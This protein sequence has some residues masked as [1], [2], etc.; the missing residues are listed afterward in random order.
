MLPEKM[1]RSAN[2]FALL[3][4]LYTLEATMSDDSSDA[5][6]ASPSPSPPPDE[7]I[8]VPP[9]AYREPASE[10][11]RITPPTTPGPSVPASRALTAAPA[12]PNVPI[13]DLANHPAILRVQA[14]PEDFELQE[15]PRKGRWKLAG[16]FRMEFLARQASRKL[17]RRPSSVNSGGV[18]K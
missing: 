4:Q 1:S 14:A 11:P 7:T 10:L 5:R 12:N 8:T 9:W 6:P 17:K 18:G 16:T 13:T 2:A 3:P 15:S